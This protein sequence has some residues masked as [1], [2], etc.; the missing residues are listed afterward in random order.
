MFVWWKTYIELMYVLNVSRQWEQT[1][2]LF[3]LHGTNM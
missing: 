2:E 3:V 1:I